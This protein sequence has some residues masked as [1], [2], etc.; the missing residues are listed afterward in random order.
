MKSYKIYSQDDSPV[1]K[2]TYFQDKLHQ[3]ANQDARKTCDFAAVL[4]ILN[5]F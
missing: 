5:E 4:K 2:E 1:N 3:V